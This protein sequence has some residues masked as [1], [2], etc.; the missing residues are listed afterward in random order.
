MEWERQRQREEFKR[1]KR[2]RWRMK[3]AKGRRR[4]TRKWTE[5]ETVTYQCA[6]T[7]DHVVYDRL[8]Y[9]FRSVIGTPNT[10]QGLNMNNKRIVEESK[11]K[12]KV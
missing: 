9:H 2:R 1:R 4:S 3:W 8:S 12:R 11:V 5:K 10:E 6:F 7:S